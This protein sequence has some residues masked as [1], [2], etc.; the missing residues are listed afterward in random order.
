MSNCDRVNVQEDLSSDAKKFSKSAM[1]LTCDSGRHEDSVL[2]SQVTQ[3]VVCVV[4]QQISDTDKAKW[5][6]TVHL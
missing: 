1:S 4:K 5:N 3:R 6:G 2:C